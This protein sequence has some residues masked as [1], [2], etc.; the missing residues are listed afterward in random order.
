MGSTLRGLFLSVTASPGRL[1]TNMS[2]IHVYLKEDERVYCPYQSFSRVDTN[3]M[4]RP[5]QPHHLVGFVL[6]EAN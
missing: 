6:S 1:R 4:F 3:I 2:K 5:E